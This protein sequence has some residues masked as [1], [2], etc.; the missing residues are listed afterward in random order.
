MVIT[1]KDIKALMKKLIPNSNK[2]NL[3]ADLIFLERF[4]IKSLPN[5]TPQAIKYLEEQIQILKD[6][7]LFYKQIKNDVFALMKMLPKMKSELESAAQSCDMLAVDR[8]ISKIR[9]ILAGLQIAYPRAPSDL[10]GWKQRLNYAIQLFEILVS[11]LK[12]RYDSLS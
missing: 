7:I 3:K 1:E 8:F 10:M 11:E 2:R 6:Q 5:M 12:V 9:L 4:L